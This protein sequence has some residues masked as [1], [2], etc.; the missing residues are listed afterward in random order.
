M[1]R[2]ARVRLH[3]DPPDVIDRAG[4]LP[5]GPGAYRA[6][7][8]DTLAAW[9]AGEARPTMADMETLATIYACPVGYF[10]LAEPPS[11]SQELSF[12]GLH[13]ARTDPLSPV[14]LASIE[15]FRFLAAWF[16]N[17]VQDLEIDWPVTV[18]S[19]H[20]GEAPADVARRER[21]RL[22]FSPAV[23]SGWPDAN[24]AFSWWR[25]AVERLGVFVFELR[26]DPR[27]VRGAALWAS[28]RP[29]CILVN[30]HDAE[31]AAGRLFSLLH[32]YAHLTMARAGCVCDLR[33]AGLDTEMETWVN[34]IAAKTTTSTP[35][36]TRA[37]ST[38]TR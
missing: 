24:L 37:G 33:G 20:L 10:F 31:S 29:P 17:V 26:L 8:A 3:L 15:R 34:D 22:G 18:G 4:K 21:E 28:G 25:R 12:R 2:W 23:R 7:A 6:I 5:G 38:S 32:E 19:A 11:E 36:S 14:T 9:E 16:G 1:L 30:R 13:R 35:P 27:E